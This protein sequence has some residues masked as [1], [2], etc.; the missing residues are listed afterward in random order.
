MV[1]KIGSATIKAEADNPEAQKET[2]IF[3][4]VASKLKGSRAGCHSM[5]MDAFRASRCR[6]AGSRKER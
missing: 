6:G 4:F 5:N 3:P 2:Y 1:P